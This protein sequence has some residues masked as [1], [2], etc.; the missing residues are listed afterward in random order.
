MHYIL[1]VMILLGLIFLT[2]SCRKEMPSDPNSAGVTVTT[3]SSCGFLSQ[4]QVR[5]QLQKIAQSPRPK[6]KAPG[7]MC[8]AV[9]AN[10]PDYAEYICPKC[11]SRTQHYSQTQNPLNKEIIYNGK[12]ISALTYE[13]DACRRKIKEVPK[14]SVELDESQFCK[15]CSPDVKT[16]SLV[17][18]IHYPEMQKDHRYEGITSRDLDLLIHFLNG[19]KKYQYAID[20]ETAIK[21]HLEQLEKIVGVEIN[22]AQ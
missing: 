14:L 13:L 19:K 4:E 2:A 7:A 20:D 17:L 11:S 1:L 16:P 6:I 18:I 10:S 12:A 22:N 8:Y 3:V 5:Q 21:D 9:V 15:H